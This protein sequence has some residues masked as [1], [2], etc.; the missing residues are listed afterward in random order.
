MKQKDLKN[1]KAGHLNEKISYLDASKPDILNKE[2]IAIKIN[3]PENG[4]EF[5]ANLSKKKF[6]TLIYLLKQSKKRSWKFPTSRVK[7][8]DFALDSLAKE[9]VKKLGLQ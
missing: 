6:K 2:E 8:I 3:D 4:F 5:I 9:K 1:K 7:I